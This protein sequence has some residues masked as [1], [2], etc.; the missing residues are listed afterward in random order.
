MEV[1]VEHALPGTRAIVYDQAEVIPVPGVLRD[2]RG[3]EGELPGKRFVVERRKT[4]DVP[5]RD[6]K[7]VQGRARVQILEGDD[8]GI[9]VDDRRGDFLR[10][11]PAENAVGH[12]GTLP[13]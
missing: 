8:V 4:L 11:D 9:L 10:C 5:A 13:A 12:L 7:N 2:L 1:N 6:D 3:G